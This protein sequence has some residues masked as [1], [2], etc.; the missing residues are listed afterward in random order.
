MRWLGFAGAL[1][2]G[3]GAP[4]GLAA[5]PW[6][7]LPGNPGQRSPVMD[8]Y[9]RAA[10]REEGRFWL[11]REGQQPPP[12]AVNFPGLP[13]PPL[14]RPPRSQAKSGALG[15]DDLGLVPDGKGGYRGRRP[16][17]RF[18]V[19]PDGTITFSDG[20]GFEVNAVYMLGM[21]GLSVP[22]DFTDW[23][24]R[25]HGDDPYS[26]DKA[27][28]IELTRSLRDKMVDA[29]RARRLRDA[30]ADLPTRLHAI[31]QRTDLG[32][33][34]KRRL[35][36]ALWDESLDAPGSPD[37]NAGVAARTTIV[38]F[39]RTKFPAGTARAYSPDELMRLNARR[40]SPAP[41]A[42]YE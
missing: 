20:P 36:F 22:F 5:A 23:L 12:P 18:A 6:D 26:F 7:P 38:E 31:W 27:R 40:L 35:F 9:E 24:M 16:G 17:Y 25:L 19:A 13:G 4:G 28:V 15:L 33:D 8:R 1:V 32:A 3:L 42:P 37:A 30:R 34:E 14:L 2:I 39:V 10:D 29:D 21:I 11:R 41:F